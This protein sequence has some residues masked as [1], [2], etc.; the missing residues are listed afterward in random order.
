MRTESSTTATKTAAAAQIQIAFRAHRLDRLAAAVSARFALQGTQRDDAATREALDR[1]TERREKRSV[2]GVA[3][4]I[5]PIVQEAT[6]VALASAALALLLPAPLTIPPPFAV[7]GAAAWHE[8]LRSA[9][10]GAGVLLGGFVAIFGSMLALYG[11]GW[12]RALW[13]LHCAWVGGLLGVP[14]CLGIFRACEVLGW[15]LDA[16]TLALLGWNHTAAGTL[17]THWAP[18]DDERLRA[19]RRAYSAALSVALAWLLTALP[20]LT[21]VMALLL[22]GVLD[23]V[24]V[25]L[26]G[27]PVQKLDRL[28]TRR[29]AAGE[30]QP[31]GLTFKAEGLELGLGDFVIY[32]AV[33][34]YSVALGSGALAAGLV[35][36]LGG[37]ALTMARLALARQRTV[38]PALPAAIV[39]ATLLLAAAVLAW[40]PL[41]AALVGHGVVI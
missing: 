34:A 37:L 28:A 10:A 13:A 2:G 18:D 9:L 33:A 12:L 7:D 26:P 16:V 19:W 1:E 23:L 3:R 31:P 29:R 25:A 39:L 20:W 30:R 6:C 40:R 11:A 8:Q 21:A 32:G 27:A 17:L 41:G 22:L 36:V 15:P 4:R 35:G 5:R 14:F 38:T 24:L